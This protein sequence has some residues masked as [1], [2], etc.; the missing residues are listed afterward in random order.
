MSIKETENTELNIGY[1]STV[2]RMGECHSRVRG[3]GKAGGNAWLARV[4]GHDPKYEFSRKFIRANRSDV[5]QSGR[6]GVIRWTVSEPGIYEF[7]G[8]STSSTSNTEGFFEVHKNGSIRLLSKSAVLALL[9]G[10]N[11]PISGAI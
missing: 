11:Q 8:C 1:G 2:F 3:G 5:S 10:M 4:L 6:S 7:R 9:D